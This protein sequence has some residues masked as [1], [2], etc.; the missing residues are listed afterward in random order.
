M[1]V[2]VKVFLNF[3]YSLYLRIFK[4]ELNTTDEPILSNR[5]KFFVDLSAHASPKFAGRGGNEQAEEWSRT[6]YAAYD[7]DNVMG[8]RRFSFLVFGNF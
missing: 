6:L 5:L 1:L 2:S 8:E 7:N 3:K 4:A